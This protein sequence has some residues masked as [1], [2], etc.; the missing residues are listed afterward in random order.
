MGE[1]GPI[2][3]VHTVAFLYLSLFL[4]GDFYVLYYYPMALRK[5]NVVKFG[6]AD[7]RSD[8]KASTKDDIK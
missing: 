2:L 8:G 6:L 3:S 7:L 1:R 4:L 5:L